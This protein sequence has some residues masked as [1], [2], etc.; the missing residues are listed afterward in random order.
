MLNQVEV[1][2]SRGTLLTLPVGEDQN[3]FYVKDIKGLDPVSAEISSSSFGQL[4][5]EVEQ[6]A[7]R[8]KRNIVLTVGLEPDYVT[9]TISQ[10]RRQLYTFFMPKSTVTLRFISDDME[11]VSIMGTIEDMDS[12]LFVQDPEAVI[13]IINVKPDFMSLIETTLPG[14]TTAAAVDTALNYP[15]SVDTG[16]LFTLSVNRSIAGFVMN[17]T[18]PDSSQRTL[19]FQYPM[20][21]GDI[22]QLSTQAGNKF[23]TLTRSGTVKSAIGGVSPQANWLQ[24]AP[25]ANL[26]RVNVAGDA[27]PFTLKYT[28]RYGGL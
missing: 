17:Q 27:I 23:A 28:S 24:L 10:M 7:R 18:L 9:R 8:E 1:L 14:A 12:E 25:G 20:V 5:G 4:D 22:L 11:T 3:G 16:F 2:S 19:E 21:D 15:G 26:L 6:G 13:S